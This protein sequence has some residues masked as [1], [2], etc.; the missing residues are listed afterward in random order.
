M[1]PEE[2]ELRPQLLD[3][4]GLLVDVKSEKD[5]HL[6]KIIKKKRLAFENDLWGLSNSSH[7]E[8]KRF[9]IKRK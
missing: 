4:F 2:G 6:R 3:R 7:K 8:E 5:G 9:N 1:N